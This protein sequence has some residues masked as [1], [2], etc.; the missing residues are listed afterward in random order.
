MSSPYEGGEAAISAA[1][2]PRRAEPR[3]IIRYLGVSGGCVVAL[4]LLVNQAWYR[5]LE[6]SIAGDAVSRWLGFPVLVSRPQQIMFF[7][8][9]GTGPAHMLGLQ[10]TLGC[11]S[12]LLLAPLALVTGGLL[13]L[14][15]VSPGRVLLAAAV[16]TSIIVFFN[17]L[18]LVMIAEMVSWWGVQT[19][20]GWGHT[21]FGS[22][23]MLAGLAAALVAFVVVLSRKGRTRVRLT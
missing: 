10:V 19:G 18:R 14:G 16:A 13:S 4:L 2:P 9:H 3:R 20:F 17:V 23:L 21:L 7:A 11:S 6:A 1:S 12:V 15:N 5:G 8:F 22:M